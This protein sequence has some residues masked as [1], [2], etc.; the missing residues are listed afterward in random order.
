MRH[1]MKLKSVPV[2][3]ATLVFS[4][5][6]LA[7]N[8][9]CEVSSTTSRSEG[10]REAGSTTGGGTATPREGSTEQKRVLIDGSSTV[11]PD[12]SGSC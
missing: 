9:G 3:L 5:A 4:F 7:T 12:L 1:A 8:S 11:Y 2:T 6:L 10:G